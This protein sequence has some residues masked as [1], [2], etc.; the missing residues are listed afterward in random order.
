MGPIPDKVWEA[1]LNQGGVWAAL[2]LLTVSLGIG[3]T[4]LM[5][6]ALREADKR[7]CDTREKRDAEI[8]A[9]NKDRVDELKT[10]LTTV[11]N[12]TRAMEEREK[13]SAIQNA[14]MAE[15][16]NALTKAIVTSEGNQRN[17]LDGQGRIERDI[18]ALWE[19]IRPTPA[20][21]RRS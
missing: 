19:A 9:V 10:V 2:F 14:S 20:S 5:W 4:T 17:L 3:V 8:K 12:V 21:G 6:R 16:A 1:I 18:R 13:S 7:E 11:Q 15:V